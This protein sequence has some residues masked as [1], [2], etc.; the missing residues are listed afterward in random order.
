MRPQHLAQAGTGTSRVAEECAQP[1]P[2]PGAQGRRAHPR[3]AP[4]SG[5]TPL[6]RAARRPLAARVKFSTSPGPGPARRPRLR[7]FPAARRQRAGLGMANGGSGKPRRARPGSS[8]EVGSRASACS[9]RMGRPGTPSLAPGS[10]SLPGLGSRRRDLRL[11]P[12]KTEGGNGSGACAPHLGR[13]PSPAHPLTCAS[14]AGARGQR[15][16]GARVPSGWGAGPRLPAD[17]LAAP[18]PRPR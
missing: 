13:A 9:P 11:L 10:P 18:A 7:P 15:A 3:R 16:R 1:S 12:A 5:R 8:L 14:R 4:G 2:P 17:D 6:P